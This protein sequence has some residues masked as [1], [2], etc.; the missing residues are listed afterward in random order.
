MD[1]SK[2][3]KV[4]RT[5]ANL[6]QYQLAQ[7]LE[8]DKSHVSRIESRKKRLSNKLKKRLSNKLNFPIEFI[9]FLARERTSNKGLNQQEVQKVGKYLLDLLWIKKI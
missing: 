1:Y 7:V 8:V 5:A 6:E 4:I 3:I 9:D 2:A